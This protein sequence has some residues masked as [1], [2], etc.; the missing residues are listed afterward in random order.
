[1]SSIAA[2]VT[3]GAVHEPL[4]LPPLSYGLIALVLFAL[5][6]GV[7]WAFRNNHQKAVSPSELEGHGHAG[8]VGHGGHA[9]QV[10]GHR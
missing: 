6:L 9:G 4:P 2:L 10:E 1:M 5:M 3:E 8:T 7:T